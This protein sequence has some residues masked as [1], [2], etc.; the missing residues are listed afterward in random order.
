VELQNA[1]ASLIRLNEILA[2][3]TQT[4]HGRSNS[5]CNNRLIRA[6]LA[7][8]RGGMSKSQSIENRGIPNKRIACP[9][10]RT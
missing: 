7:S 9:P 10:I 1:P 5:S 8:S 4:D 6:K 3:G 2:F